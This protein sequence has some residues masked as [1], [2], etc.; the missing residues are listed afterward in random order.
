MKI[1]NMYVF[2]VDPAWAPEPSPELTKEEI[3][4]HALGCLESANKRSGTNVA[5]NCYEVEVDD[6]ELD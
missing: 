1:I 2:T 6:E 4:G 5:V 3:V